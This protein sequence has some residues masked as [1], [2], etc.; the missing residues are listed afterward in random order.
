MANK[1]DYKT[2]SQSHHNEMQLLFDKAINL[3]IR[4]IEF[5]KQNSESEYLIHELE[6][7]AQLLKKG[8]ENFA[9]EEFK[10]SFFDMPSVMRGGLGLSRGFGEILYPIKEEW[11]D[12]IMA[13]VRAIEKYFNEM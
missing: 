9:N 7:G 12:E 6:H 4:R 1:F 3:I 2:I 8:K 11:A 10:K 5:L 13:A